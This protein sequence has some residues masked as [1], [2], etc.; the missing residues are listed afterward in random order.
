[1]SVCARDQPGAR[2]GSR[3]GAIVGGTASPRKM[4]QREEGGGEQAREEG[5]SKG[6]SANSTQR[7][8]VKGWGR[9]QGRWWQDGE[10]KSGM[11]RWPNRVRRTPTR[12]RAQ[13]KGR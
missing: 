1:M 6:T 4:G 2:K 9:R 11:P 3:K 7:R 5:G 12:K 13:A 8:W 10:V